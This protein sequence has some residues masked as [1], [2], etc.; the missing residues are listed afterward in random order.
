MVLAMFALLAPWG[1]YL[2]G[3]F[4]P[5]AYWQGW[6]AMHAPEGDYVVFVRISPWTKGRSIY[7][8]LSG[9]SIRGSGAVC[10][11]MAKF[12]IGCG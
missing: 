9:P 5:L 6:G 10:S 11:L 4:H 1:F 2:G 3:H 12:M 8:S 7:P